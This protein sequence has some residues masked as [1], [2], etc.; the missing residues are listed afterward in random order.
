M[1]GDRELLSDRQMAESQTAELQNVRVLLEEARL[2]IANLS[3][4]R[5]RRLEAPIRAVLRELNAQLD[6]LSG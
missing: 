6:E 5:R 2:Q 4:V 3:E 1:T